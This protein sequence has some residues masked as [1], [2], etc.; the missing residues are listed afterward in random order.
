L[1]APLLYFPVLLFIAIFPL[2]LV[3]A[4][5]LRSELLRQHFSPVVSLITAALVLLAFGI[6]GHF[7]FAIMYLGSPTF[8]DHIEPNTA[9]ISWIYAQGGQIYHSLDAPERYAFLY[10]P[11]P[12]IAT[13]WMYALLGGSTFAAKIAGFICLL[14]TSVFILLAVWQRFS[15]RIIPCLVALGY[16]SLIALFFKNHSFWSKPDPFLMACTAIGLY[17]C[18]LRPGRMAWVLCGIALGIA[19]NAKIT[20][21]L[22]FLPY[23][24]WFFD[25]DG[26]RALLVTSLAAAVTALLP[27]W[28]MDQVSIINYTA[29][30][31]AAGGHGISRLLLL[32]NLVFLIFILIPPGCFLFWQYGSVGIRSWF[33]T[34]R[35]IFVASILAALL[36]LLAASKSGSGPHHFLPFLPAL[37]FLVA[38]A[39][40]R[41]YSYRPTTN[42]SVYGFWAPVTAFL[43]AAIIKAGLALYFGLKVVMAQANGDLIAQN[44]AEIVADNPGRNIYMGYGDG[45]RYT[46]TFLRTELAYAGHPYLIDASALMDFQHSG[47]EIPQVTIDHMLADKSSIWLIPAGQEPFEI[48]N[49]YYRFQGRF[50]F[51]DNFRSAFNESFQRQSSTDFF[52]LYIQRNQNT[53]EP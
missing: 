22:Y 24:A 41:V 53:S 10:G 16:F 28:A 1:L 13:S 11:V 36:L 47:M 25:R 4:A 7:L 35:L 38:V 49:W 6:A 50:L 3:L 48:T 40:S 14:T 51:E 23:L 32:Q 12:Y 2:T 52:D 19:V 26:Y 34:Y 27:Y 30:L 37:A 29:W 9:I 5:L 33:D 8:T 31:Q 21:V 18:L 45:S 15:G 17:S 46:V 42:W 20:G 44:L 43:L 39:T